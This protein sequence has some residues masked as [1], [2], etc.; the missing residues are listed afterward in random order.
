MS[1]SPVQDPLAVVQGIKNDIAGFPTLP[2]NFLLR[3]IGFCADPREKERRL[4]NVKEDLLQIGMIHEE[5]QRRMETQRKLQCMYLI[6][7]QKRTEAEVA[8]IL[9]DLSVHDV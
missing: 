9:L 4:Q 6:Q 2:Y 8:N 5:Q 3:H 1:A 7:K